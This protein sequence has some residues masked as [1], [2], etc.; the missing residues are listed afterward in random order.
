M[1]SKTN[2]VCG[3]PFC[4]CSEA[5]KCH[6]TCFAIPK[7]MQRFLVDH[8]ELHSGCTKRRLLRFRLLSANVLI[9]SGI[10]KGG[11]RQVSSS[12]SVPYAG[13]ALPLQAE[14]VAAARLQPL[15][16]YVFRVVAFQ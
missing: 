3:T 13:Q 9:R 7:S 5:L 8:K 1:Q 16:Q 4:S 2:S 10:I 11:Y 6:G 15:R 14:H 12:G